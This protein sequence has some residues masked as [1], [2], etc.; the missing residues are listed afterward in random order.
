MTKALGLRNNGSCNYID[1]GV[2]V[3]LNDPFFRSRVQT[4]Q[5]A[6]GGTFKSHIGLS[7]EAVFLFQQAPIFFLE[8]KANEKKSPAKNNLKYVPRR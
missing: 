8:Q 1:V 3:Q 7:H 2:S 4:Q 5:P 6:L